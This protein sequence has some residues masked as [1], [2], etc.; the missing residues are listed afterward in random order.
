MFFVYYVV[1]SVNNKNPEFQLLKCN[2]GDDDYTH[3]NSHLNRD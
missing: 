2:D 3:S 1:E